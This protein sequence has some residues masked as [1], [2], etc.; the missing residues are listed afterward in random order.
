MRFLEIFSPV[1]AF[2]RAALDKLSKLDGNPG[3]SAM[4]VSQL[5]TAIVSVQASLEKLTGR[6]RHQRV[7]EWLKRTGKVPEWA[8]PMIV[9]VAYEIAKR[10]GL[11]K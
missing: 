10:T 11:M 2:L 6:E 1:T 9:Y 3:L 5:L 7:E 4:D 8:A